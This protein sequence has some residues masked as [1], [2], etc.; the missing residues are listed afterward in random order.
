MKAGDGVR[1]GVCAR[2]VCAPCS[3]GVVSMCGG[4]T[5]MQV[6]QHA[7]YE[8]NHIHR[9]DQDDVI[10][11]G[12]RAG[13]ARDVDGGVEEGMC[14][15]VGALIA[16]AVEGRVFV[17]IMDD[18]ATHTLLRTVQSACS[19]HSKVVCVYTCINTCVDVCHRL[20]GVQVL[21]I[22]PDLMPIVNPLVTFTQLTQSGTVLM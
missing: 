21:C 4:V 18:D 9:T 14:R 2:M 8:L 13:R 20:G 19:Q 5:A 6:M 12:E 10:L 15:G 1:S 16:V 11:Q 7:I 17:V 22:D 3:E